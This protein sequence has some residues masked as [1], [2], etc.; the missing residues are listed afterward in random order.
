VMGGGCLDIAFRVAIDS[1]KGPHAIQLQVV[2]WRKVG[3]CDG[4]E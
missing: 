2:E 4:A 1:Y 3:D